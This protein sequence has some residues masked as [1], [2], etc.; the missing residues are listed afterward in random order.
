V[1][2]TGCRSR[3]P[4]GLNP[5][6]HRTV[7]AP[8]PTDVAPVNFPP[9]RPSPFSVGLRAKVGGTL[10]AAV[11]DFDGQRAVVAET[12]VDERRGALSVADGDTLSTAAKL[13]LDE[14]LPL[15]A[16]L[17]S[18]GAETA[19]GV[20]AVDGWGRAARRLVACSGVVPII[21]VVTGPTV[22]G[23]ALLL[24]LADQVI[25]TDDA[26]AFVSGPQMVREFTGESVTAQSL[27]GVGVHQ[28]S[29][30]TASLVVADRAAGRDAAGV[31]LSYL[32]AH[33]DEEPHLW[34][35]DDPVDRPTT[36][37]GDLL[38]LSATGSYDVRHVIGE[39]VDDGELVELRAP[40]APNLVT[41]LAMIGGRPV[42]VIANQPQSVAGTL[43][44]PASQKGARFVAFCDS[45]NLPLITFVDTPG[46][47]PG[48]DLEW[49]GMIRHG[50]Q[51]AF[52]YAQATVPRICVTLRK[53]YGGAYIVMDSRS[54]GNDL[55]LA[56]PGAEIAVMG[57]KGAVGILHRRETPEAR[58]ALEADYE[59]RFLNPYVAAERGLIDRVIDPAATRIELHRGLEVL[60]TKREFIPTRR[61]D[62][63][64]L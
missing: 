3:V 7:L 31:L 9:S 33:T 52:A 51:L 29:T 54:M 56:W 25:M 46:F 23:P 63:T 15:V 38:P 16:F 30:G 22:A 64:P 61:H 26:Y 11:E 10:R 47:Y 39:I 24:G 32:P 57:A 20:A 17:E 13:A 59:E 34:P 49:R 60:A 21:V 50:A 14:K 43:D 42:G 41:M 12:W 40:W 44:I 19:A 48:K 2:N 1:L 8:S 37:A 5:P 28:R 62:N 45:F 27:G 4:Q 18:T 6:R 35:C 55:Q 58:L 36:E 53:S